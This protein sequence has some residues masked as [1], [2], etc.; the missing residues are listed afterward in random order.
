[1]QR[2]FSHL[3][4]RALASGKEFINVNSTV[5]NKSSKFTCYELL[6]LSKENVKKIILLCVPFHKDQF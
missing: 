2:C 6:W 5:N 4:C 3:Y 1:M